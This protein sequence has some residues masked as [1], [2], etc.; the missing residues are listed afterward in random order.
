MSDD[1]HRIRASVCKIHF[2]GKAFDFDQPYNLHLTARPSRGTGFVLDAFPDGLVVTAYHVVEHAS[3]IQCEFIHMQG[4]RVEATLVAYSLHLDVALLRIVADDDT[5]TKY[6]RTGN[7]D[8]VKPTAPVLAVGFALGN[9]YQVTSGTVSGRTTSLIQVDCAVNGGNSGGPLLNDADEVVGVVV[10]GYDPGAAQN[11]NFVAPIFETI[12]CLHWAL[13]NGVTSVPER[14]LNATI[15]PSASVLYRMHG[16]H[17]TCGEG[18]CPHGGY[19]TQVHPE[20]SLYKAGMRRK[21]V[22]CAIDG[23]NVDLRGKIAVA[24]WG[25]DRLG[26]ETLLE[27]KHGGEQMKIRFWS[28]R[29]CTVREATV[30]VE[31]N[32]STFRT[33][34]PLE[35]PPRYSCRGGIVVQSLVQNHAKLSRAYRHLFT[36][37]QVRER[38]LLVVTFV[39]P[40]SPFTSMGSVSE[41]D[42]VVYVND[43]AVRAIDDYVDEWRRWQASGEPYLTISLYDGNIAVATRKD[44]LESEVTSRRETGLETLEVL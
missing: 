12:T 41:G 5:A 42:I 33:V 39:R 24:W 34:D 9:D 10:S 31:R 37:P 6:L 32:L 25:V 13:Q 40:E 35:T 44:I 7:S 27:R 2:H 8:S 26:V 20:S 36:Q 19:V 29:H 4:R 11:I 17:G 23:Y 21:D 30:D 18:V 22:L 14:S 15:V 28:H 43:R 16:G 1:A 3:R 38:S